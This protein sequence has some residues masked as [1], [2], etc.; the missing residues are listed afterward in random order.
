MRFKTRFALKDRQGESKIVRKF[1]WIPT[2]FAS[3][4][5]SRWLEVADV[6]YTIKRVARGDWD[7]NNIWK[8]RKDRFATDKDY[9]D[10]PFESSVDLEDVFEKYSVSFPTVLVKYK[11]NH[12][13]PKNVMF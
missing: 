7:T 2:A 3:E 9:A 4:K 12:F 10:L 8:W 1:L 13:L 6:V 11:S 5:E